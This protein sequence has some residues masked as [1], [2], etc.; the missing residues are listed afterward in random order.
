MT[1]LIKYN[2]TPQFKS[3][4]KGI[5]DL[6]FKLGKELPPIV[7]T[8]TVKLHGTNVS[9][10]FHGENCDTH[11]LQSR[12]AILTD[13]EDTY[14]FYAFIND[15]P[16]ALE[17]LRA[18]ALRA[19]KIVGGVEPIQIF[20]EWVGP[21][22]QKKVGIGRIPEKMMFVFRIRS[23]LDNLT[24]N[25]AVPDSDLMPDD[26]HGVKGS[27]RIRNIMAFPTYQVTVDFTSPANAI[28]EM[29]AITRKIDA[30]CPV[31]T[32]LLADN[33]PEVVTGE[34][35]CW[36]A[37][38]Y[39]NEADHFVKLDAFDPGPFDG[40]DLRRIFFKTKGAAHASSKV[41]VFIPVDAE[42]MNSITEF[43]EYACT[44]NRMEQGVEEMRAQAKPINMDTMSD[45]LTWVNRDI[46]KEEA[47]TLAASN[48]TMKEVGGPI[49]RK[50]RM[51]WMQLTKKD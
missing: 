10:V 14:G 16:Q 8:G 27:T 6:A 29:E 25:W 30:V 38:G 4:V 41:K 7:L 26:L 28:N 48:L 36:M 5:R 9:I 42:K 31:T 43:V 44:Q 23:S 33:L 20:G 1:S 47:D 34:G 24:F 22:V 18:I 46:L 11:H 50:A 35:A 2:S 40:V 37:T 15:N 51:F 49:S 32:T 39:I 45:F 17:D 21:G 3:V 19:R 13:A 12:E